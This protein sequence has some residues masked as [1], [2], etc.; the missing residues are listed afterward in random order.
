MLIFWYCCQERREVEI[1]SSFSWDNSVLTGDYWAD[2]IST[3]WG[4]WGENKSWRPAIGFLHR[5]IEPYSELATGVQLK[6]NGY[7]LVLNKV[8][9][10]LSV[11]LSDWFLF[12]I[13]FDFWRRRLRRLGSTGREIFQTFSFS[14]KLPLIDSSNELLIDVW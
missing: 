8:P 6:H 11:V 3:W 4:K 7:N 9:S 1:L 13:E 12:E 10:T 14:F 5:Q 2:S